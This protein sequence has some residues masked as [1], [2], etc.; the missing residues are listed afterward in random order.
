MNDIEIMDKIKKMYEGEKSK[1]FILHLIHS[2]LPIQVRA[3]KFVNLEKSQGKTIKCAITNVPLY[4]IDDVLTMIDKNQDK[5]KEALLADVHYVVEHQGDN[6]PDPARPNMLK[7]MMKGHVLAW[8]GLETNTFLCQQ[9]LVQ[10]N[11]FVAHQLLMGDHVINNILIK[12]KRSV[13]ER[14]Y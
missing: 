10:L 12:T 5:F 8:T 1:K 14:G 7:E 11:E 2:Y 4:T 3:T 9:A 6:N 13:A